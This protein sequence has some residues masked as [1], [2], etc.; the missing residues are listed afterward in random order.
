MTGGKHPGH[1]SAAPLGAGERPVLVVDPLHVVRAGIEMLVERQTGF[2]LA[3]SAST[4]EEAFE[5]LRG[6]KRHSGAIVLV[7]LA[8]PGER[9][10]FW[11]IRKIREQF[12]TAVAVACGASSDTRAISRALFAGADGYVDKGSSP[13]EFF[14]VLARCA[15]GEVTIGGP[16][17]GSISDL[18]DAFEQQMENEPTLTSRERDVL[19][20]AAEGLTARQ[21]G[22]R[23]G[24]RERT[25]TTHL[26]RIYSKLGVNSRVAA[27]SSA[28]RSGLFTE[29]RSE[30]S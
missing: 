11:L 5:Q 9:D 25:V 27:I 18:A 17:A 4:A 10:A 15:E 14:G 20:V 6:L 12:P 23:L 29:V 13:E 30:L 1:G 19:Q 16:E 26:A 24:L 8:L 7:A 28:T 22:D 2:V 21:I 3:G